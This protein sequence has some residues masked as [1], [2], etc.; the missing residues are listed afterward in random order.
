M[1]KFKADFESNFTTHLIV[2]IIAAICSVL[3][4]VISTEISMGKSLQKTQVSSLPFNI[5]QTVMTDIITRKSELW[6]WHIK[7]WKSVG[8]SFYR[9]S[10]KK[11]KRLPLYGK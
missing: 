11:I 7:L 5:L 6:A 9:A 8:Q 1:F 10:G 2:I 4:M 3:F